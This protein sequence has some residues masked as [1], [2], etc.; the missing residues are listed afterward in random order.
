MYTCFVSCH[1]CPCPAFSYSVLRRNDSL[2]VSLENYAV[3]NWCLI[4]NLCLVGIFR[5]GEKHSA[6]RHERQKQH[7]KMCAADALPSGLDL[8]WPERHF[9]C[10]RRFFFLNICERACLIFV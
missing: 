8:L 9:G 5:H 10:K 4:T 7:W 3:F 1:Y 6:I 2:L